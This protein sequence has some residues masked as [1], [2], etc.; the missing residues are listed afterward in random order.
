MNKLI[1]VVGLFVTLSV[2]TFNPQKSYA[3]T[4]SE[5]QF[6]IFGGVNTNPFPSIVGINGYI[7]IFQALRVYVGFDAG[8]WAKWMTDGLTAI[9]LS[10]GYGAQLRIPGLMITPIIGIA[11][12]NNKVFGSPSKFYGDLTTTAQFLTG[13]IGLEFHPNGSGW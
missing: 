6:G 12:S 2:A 9:E 5:L 13:Q 4:S 7:E 11:S 8:K 10:A 1:L 3:A